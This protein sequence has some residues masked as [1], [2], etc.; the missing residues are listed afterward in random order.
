VS[1]VSRVHWKHPPSSLLSRAKP[2]EMTK[3]ML[4][5]YRWVKPKGAP[6][7]ASETWD[8]SNQFSLEIP[9]LLFVIPSTH[10]NRGTSISALSPMR[11]PA[12]D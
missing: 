6:G 1:Q 4:S 5:A 8:P 3:H 11:S 7:L 12:P 2:R 10:V 9:T